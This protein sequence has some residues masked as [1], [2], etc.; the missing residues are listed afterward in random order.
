MIDHERAL[1]LAAAAFDFELSREDDDALTAH[2]EGCDACRATATALR[3][4]AVALGELERD[5]APAELRGR[6]VAAA[7][8]GSDTLDEALPAPSHGPSSILMRFPARLRHQAVLVAAAAVVV[9]VVGGTLAWRTVPSDR[10]IA[11]TNPSNPPANGSGDPGAG[12]PG[13]PGGP[14]PTNP[15]GPANPDLV[16]AWTPVAEL[17]AQKSAGGV[18]DVD[19]GFLLAALGRTPATELASRVTVRPALQLKATREADGRVRL[20]PAEPLTPGTVYRFTLSGDEGQTLDSWAFQA[21]Q[22]LRIVSTLP[23]N[24]ETEVRLDTGIEVTFDQDGVVDPAAH[25]TIE[26]KV[27]GRFEQH[28]RVL[29]FI[30]ERQLAPATI[31]TVTISRGVAVGATGEQ[32]EA[33]VQFR[34]ETAAAGEAQ[35]QQTTFQFA[36]DLFESATADRPVVAVWAFGDFNENGDQQ[37]PDRMPLE[38]YRLADRAAAIDTFRVLRSAQRWSRWHADADVPTAGLTRIA[39]FDARL[40]EIGGTLWTRLPEALPEGWYLVQYP[41][42]SGP[43]QAVLQVTDISAYLMVSET[44]TLVW[45]NDLATKKPVARADVRADGTALGRTGPDGTLVVT[46]PGALLPERDHA[47]EDGCAPVVTVTSGGRSAFLPATGSSGPDGVAFGDGWSGSSAHSQYWNVFHTDRNRYRRTDTVNVWGMLR[48]RS[49]GK[50]PESV[51]LRLVL[52]ADESSGA[53]PPIVQAEASPRPTGAFTGSLDLR[54]VPEG[55][56]RVELV[57]DGEVVASHGLEVGRILKPAYQ[58]EV[59]TGR[60]VYIAGDQI[61]VTATARFYE[62]TPVP[63]VPLKMSGFL[64]SSQTTDASGTAI[65]RGTAQAWE[66]DDGEGAHYQTVWVA[67]GRP[68]EG[69]IQG[70]SREFIVFPSMW[71]V[72]AESEIRA[73]RVRI[74][75]TVNVVDR[76]RL[77]GEIAGG[78]EVWGLD[79]RGAPVAGR[80]VRIAFTEHIPIRTQMGTT[81]DFI[82]KRVVP[83]YRYETQ[84]RSAG[85]LRIRTDDRGRFSGS[86][87]ASAKDHDYSVKV[88][89]TDPDGHVAHTTTYAYQRTQVFDW[90][91]E[92]Y[93]S[94][95]EQGDDAPRSFGIG[96]ALDVTMRGPGD[97]AAA[98]DRHLFYVAQQGLRAFAVHP[99]S[100]FVTTFPAWGPPNV[101]VGAV[102]FT[103]AGYIIGGSYFAAFR[104]S[105]RAI[106]IDLQADRER[107]SPG[108]EVTLRVRTRGPSGRALPAT[109]VLS[110]VDEKLYSIGAA[111]PDDPLPELYASLEAGI[112]ASYA[113]HQTPRARPGSGDTGG[114]G[115]GEFRD[116]V[117]FRA[118]D[119]GADGR[120]S[121][122]FRLSADLTSWRVSASAIGAG[123]EAGTGSAKIPVG[124]PFFVEASIAPEYLS[125]DRPV[126]QIRGFGTALD[127]ADRVTFAV[128]ATSL[129]LHETGLPADAFEAVT[130]RLPRLTLGTH[131]LTITGRTGSGSTARTHRVIR[132]FEVVA[133]RLTRTS[134]RYEEPSGRMRVEGG[135]GLT[136]IVVSDASSGQELPLLL[137]LASGGGARLE[138]A[139]A[140][141]VAAALIVERFGAGHVD[142]TDPAFDGASYQRSDGGIAILPYASSDLEVST[143]TALV[144]PDRFNGESLKSYFR[145]IASSNKETRERHNFALAGLAGTGDAVL[146]A[147]R[148]ATADPDLTIRERLVLGLGAAALGDNATARTVAASLV[149]DYGEAVNQGARLRAGDDSADVA[150]ATSWLAMLM[151]GVGDPVA[152]RYRAYVQANPSL[153]ATYALQ[154][155]GYADRVLAHRAPEPASF[156]YEVGG[157]RKVVKLEPGQSFQLTVTKAQLATLRIARLDGSIGVTTSWREPIKASS[158][159]K[160]PDVK[161]RR[162]VKPSGTIDGSDLV[163]VDLGVTFGPKAAKGCHRVTDLVPS[164]LVPV[165]VLRGLVDQET[166]EVLSDISYPEEQSGQRVVFCAEFDP[167]RPT[168]RLRY[169]ARVIT[170]GTYTWEPTVAE[171]RTSANRAA[172]VPADEIT[173]R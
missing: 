56:Y 80:T 133:S 127:P 32:L 137:E 86:I 14:V 40:E 87:P 116:S 159:E 26:P 42:A 90:D 172:T 30:P 147:I 58:L 34:F 106:S 74:S 75:G 81:Y 117:L 168:V 10:G 23:E 111:A 148:A 129:G 48:D 15:A 163:V 162:I 92:S 101:S 11:V 142:P 146:P 161:I 4:D 84:D 150:S 124:L 19:T 115:D 70:A 165:G 13:G 61:R 97:R 145:T 169:V 57:E 118:V 44:Q 67:P 126:I 2:L 27:D 33:D 102:R 69:E 140:A 53:N 49:N 41:S 94:L 63:G 8:A 152:F 72:G 51:T 141:D 54:E 16:T 47:C 39:G 93:V 62:G 59:V 22:P 6:I 167:A 96:E 119:T 160:D 114:G 17:T 21:R 60:R 157:T 28:D 139:L 173:I 134:T 64:E 82:E 35:P 37:W 131:K 3:A 18:V 78:S 136:D 151:A 135:S 123:L 52:S 113:S 68:E 85:T 143:L 121:V 50:V 132:S 110:A 43:S 105:D 108:D 100:R 29:A 103:G 170:I 79:P 158:F 73:G 1:D 99:S 24:H 46:T 5:D 88:S 120:A 153:E 130:V 98:D 149:K 138:R 25:M 7:S 38:V 109:V 65:A 122:T 95:T 144:A 91:A 31:Y 71:T 36:S 112:R 128:D 154:E 66:G 55:Y 76:D 12:S 83:V 171:S 125:S 107:Y 104:T 155:V 166:G 20:T 156:A 9:A 77:E 164:G 45:A 89:L